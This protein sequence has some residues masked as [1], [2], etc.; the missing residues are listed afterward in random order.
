MS[1]K[2]DKPPPRLSQ[3]FALV[4]AVLFAAVTGVSAVGGEDPRG[5]IVN[6]GF[7][8]IWSC[9]ALLA[10]GGVV[11]PA[12]LSRFVGNAPLVLAILGMFVSFPALF[13]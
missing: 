6:V 7:S 9:V 13:I 10:L 11:G 8:L 2:D 5:D 3:G 12:G 4:I 1:A